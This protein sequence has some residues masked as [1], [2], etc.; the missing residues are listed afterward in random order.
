M[1]LIGVI[2][3]WSKIPPDKHKQIHCLNFW[4]RGVIWLKNIYGIAKR[5]IGFFTVIEWVKSLTMHIRY[6]SKCLVSAS[7]GGC[8]SDLLLHSYLI[9]SLDI[10]I[11]RI[12]ARLMSCD[13][14]WWRL[15]FDYQ[16]HFSSRII[17]AHLNAQYCFWVKD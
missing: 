15:K 4:S 16:S 5:F 11:N 13:R 2:N 12:I 10:Y 3:L 17:E 7:V 6:E 8:L 1:I 9:H 14:C